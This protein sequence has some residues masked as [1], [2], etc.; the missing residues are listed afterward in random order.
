MFL[1]LKIA[2]EV[3]GLGGCRFTTI[4]SGSHDDGPLVEERQIGD[5]EEVG[6]RG[7][8]INCV[9]VSRRHGRAR[10]DVNSVAG[11]RVVLKRLRKPL[12]EPLVVAR[13]TTSSN[14]VAIVHR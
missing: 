14:Q 2:K 6:V 7:H 10:L 9:I 3:D 1:A 5:H 8:V 4:V 12:D 11:D 13:Q